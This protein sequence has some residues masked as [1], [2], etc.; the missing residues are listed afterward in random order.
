MIAP[1][2]VKDEQIRT[3]VFNAPIQNLR[4][5]AAAR[6]DSGCV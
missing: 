1:D 6:T 4:W 5:R 2:M 3:A